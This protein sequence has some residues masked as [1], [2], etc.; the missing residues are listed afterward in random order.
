MCTIDTINVKSK[1]TDVTIFFSGAQVVR[2]AEIKLVKGKYLIKLENLP[3]EINPQS[4][5]VEGINNCKIL[6]VKNELNYQKEN[7]KSADEII[8]QNKIDAQQLKIKEIKNKLSVYDIEEKLLMDN[9][10]LGKKDQ[11]A[12]VA[13][14]KEAADYYRLRLNEIRQGKLNLSVDVESFKKKM[15]ELYLQLNELSATKSKVFSQLLI[16]LD[17]E[18]ETNSILKFSYYVPSAGWE[19][20]YDFRVED[21]IKPL[22]I[23]YNAN[24]YQ[25]SGEDWNNVNIK[26]SNNNPSL[27]G[28]KPELSTWYLGRKYYN[29]NEPIKKGEATLRGRV[30]DSNNSEVLAF[31]NIM[32]FQGD[33]LITNTI[34][35]ADGQY[36]IKPI[37]SGTYNIRVAYVGYNPKQINN[38]EIVADKITYQDFKLQP[39]TS[40]KE[41]EIVNYSEPLI[42]ANALSGSKVT[43]EEYQNMA[44]KNINSVAST[45]AGIYQSDEASNPYFR[46]SRSKST[47]YYVDGQKVK[48]KFNPNL[49][50]TT[51]NIANT[52]KTTVANLEYSIEIPYS[53]PSDGA[54]YNIKIKEVSL[55]VNYVY[56][57]IPKL[58]NDAF[59]TA[60]IINWNQLNLL[61]GKSSIYYQGTF[62][63][64]S[65]IDV[66]NANDTLNISLGRDKNIIVKREGNKEMFDKKIIGSNIKETIGWDI[67]VKNNKNSKIKIVIEDQYPISE[68][69]SIE[70]EL[71]ESSNA[72]VDTKTGKLVWELQIDSNDKK[73]LNYKYSVKYPK[74]VNVIT[75]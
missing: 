40:L 11:G 29:S 71:L 20:T 27:S 31:V 9:S 24:V 13:E 21:I 70:V 5:Q 32:V 34:T 8:A 61:S 64:E 14:I 25:S 45:T 60:E 74:D 52:L 15:Q 49:P 56:H 33:K 17:C 55:P 1:I 16:T 6:S 66:N 30:F 10:I 47:E 2:N 59:L 54:D 46:G 75:E 4:I 36:I 12:T 43:R 58:D 73:T 69:K 63:G 44:S 51:D 35:D 37:K 72:K 42:D 19:P 67:A 28:N 18:K 53:I 62:T 26:L 39:G 65:E 50:I 41:V 68:K 57:C 3:Q 7:K 38:L 48:E 22:V 23:V